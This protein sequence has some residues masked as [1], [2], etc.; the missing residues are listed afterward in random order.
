MRF[1]KV[2]AHVTF[3]ILML[4]LVH[5]EW[6]LYCVLMPFKR[7]IDQAAQFTVA[8]DLPMALEN[9]LVSSVVRLLAS[10][11]PKLLEQLQLPLLGLTLQ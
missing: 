4:S 10:A 7:T 3:L 11:Q 6:A 8:T 5:R 2:A 9:P 1:L